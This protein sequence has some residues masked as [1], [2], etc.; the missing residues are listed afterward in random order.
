[1]A[2]LVN[3]SESAKARVYVGTYKKY[4]GGSLTGGW[5]TL[6]DYEDYDEFMKACKELHSDEKDPEFMFQDWENIPEGAIG[7]CSINPTIWAAFD[8]LE[9]DLEAFEAFCE[10]I[11]YI[12]VNS[13]FSEVA[14]KFHE[15]YYGQFNSEED[16]AEQYAEET[17]LLDKIPEGLRCY[18]DFAAFA[19]DLFLGGFRFVNGYVFCDC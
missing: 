1:M 13:D 15:K 5:L 19:R 14:E 6:Q 10:E 9:S 8:V 12:T 17:C 2:N 18:F 7:E 11:E 4:N 3:Y 16:F